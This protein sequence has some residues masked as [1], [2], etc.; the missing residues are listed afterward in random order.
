[1]SRYHACICF[2]LMTRI[3][4]PG[5]L[6]I[7]TFLFVLAAAI[8][9]ASPVILDGLETGKPTVLTAAEGASLDE[10]AA[11]KAAGKVGGFDAAQVT[12]VFASAGRELEGQAGQQ[13]RNAG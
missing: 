4:L 8:L 11:T 2:P 10:S 3:G 5:A 12:M 9:E 7:A 6:A 1:M 13:L